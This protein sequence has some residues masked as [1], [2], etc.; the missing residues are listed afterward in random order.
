MTKNKK[1]ICMTMQKISKNSNR[2]QPLNK[3]SKDK[4]RYF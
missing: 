1:E 2:K 4:E 3:E